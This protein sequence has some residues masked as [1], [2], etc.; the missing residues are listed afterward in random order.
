MGPDGNINYSCAFCGGDVDED[1]HL[2]TLHINGLHF[3]NRECYSEYILEWLDVDDFFYSCPNCDK[4]LQNDSL[5]I[6]DEG[7]KFCSKH[8]HD[9]FWN[10]FQI[11]KLLLR[12]EHDLIEYYI[13]VFGTSYELAGTQYEGRPE[14]IKSIHVGDS[15]LL[16][17]EPDNPYDM[18][19]ISVRNQEGT[20]GYIPSK[21]TYYLAPFLDKEA[22]TATAHVTSITPVAER[23][24]K[25]NSKFFSLLLFRTEIP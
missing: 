10:N 12:N 7:H 24:A 17:R 18:R 21:F 2:P 4:L 14:R 8:C 20:L 13:E 11:D 25:S 16:V 19:A 22:L 23:P 5:Y 6:D 9:E 1:Y 3:C 15:L